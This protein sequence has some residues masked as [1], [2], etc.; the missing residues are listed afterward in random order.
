MLIRDKEREIEGCRNKSIDSQSLLTSKERELK[1]NPD[2]D[3]ELSA[4]LPSRD[5]V[6]YDREKKP[7]LPGAANCLRPGKQLFRS[8]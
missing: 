3:N 2:Y 5:T 8:F 6:R 1:Q 7:S 4:Y